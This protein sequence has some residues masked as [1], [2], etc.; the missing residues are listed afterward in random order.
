MGWLTRSSFT[1]YGPS[2]LLALLVVGVA[3]VGIVRELRQL[4]PERLA[5]KLRPWLT[6][7]L[8][9]QVLAWRTWILAFGD[10]DVAEDLPFQLCSLSLILLA[11]YLWAPSQ[12]LFDVLFHWVLGGSIMGILV[13]NLAFEFPHPRFWS[14]FLGH[15]SEILVMAYLVAV[16]GHRPS[17]LS[18]RRAIGAMIGYAV[19]GATPLN[20]ALDAN[21][22]YLMDVP[23][24]D[25]ALI[26]LLPPW[27]WYPLVVL[28]FF[29]LLF[30][31]IYHVAVA[32]EPGSD[33]PVRDV[34]GQHG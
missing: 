11:V 26:E 15:G 30:Q 13:P 27:P 7:L 18:V 20:L 31:G 10:F 32:V 3:I 21:Y 28:A 23:N 24:V 16:L 25:L 19:V 1:L 2:H 8:L 12:R 9:F 22:L 5:P 34:T 14:M 6:A 4:D 29:S 17:A 33:R